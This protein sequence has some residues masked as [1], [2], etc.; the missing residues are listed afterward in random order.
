MQTQINEILRNLENQFNDI[1]PVLSR[2]ASMINGAIMRNFQAH[3]RWNGNSTDI[4]I[5]SGGSQKWTALAG[6]TKRGYKKHGFTMESTLNRSNGLKSTIEVGPNG[7]RSVAIS[8]NSP[9]AAIHQHGGTIKHPGGTPYVFGKDKLP[10]FISLRKA[11]QLEAKGR[12]VHYTK[13]HRIT[14]PARP[15]IVLAPEDIEDIMLVIQK[16]VVA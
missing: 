14:I 12:K 16:Y 7:K 10:V 3:G 13:P 4:N 9:Y 6:S 1:S 5:F 15:Y 8:A 11:K 2:I